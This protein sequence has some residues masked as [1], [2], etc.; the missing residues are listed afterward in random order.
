MS[1]YKTKLL[2]KYLN[3]EYLNDF[4]KKKFKEYVD[5]TNVFTYCVYESETDLLNK[6]YVMWSKL[7]IEKTNFEFSKDKNIVKFLNK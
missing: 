6:E 7:K 4:E 2:S 1:E 3:G 5:K